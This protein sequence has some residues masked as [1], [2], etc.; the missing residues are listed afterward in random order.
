MLKILFFITC[1]IVCNYF[2]LKETLKFRK[3]KTLSQQTIELSEKT[4][5]SMKA[6]IEDVVPICEAKDYVL[7][8]V[9]IFV[10]GLFVF[11]FSIHT[12]DLV[13]FFPLLPVYFIRRNHMF[14]EILPN[15][16][17]INHRFV[18]WEDIKS[19]ERNKITPN[20]KYYGFDLK[21]NN[22]TELV[23]KLRNKWNSTISYSI[24]NKEVEDD[25]V[26]LLLEKGSVEEK[27]TCD[28]AEIKERIF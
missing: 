13:M 4:R 10:I 5:K 23:F 3:I 16:L 20:H 22:A 11:L 1:F 2:L 12:G 18:R 28:R 27:D 25:F 7:L 17:I 19:F 9:F 26:S 24:T 8:N 21:I 6:G 14:F 15:G